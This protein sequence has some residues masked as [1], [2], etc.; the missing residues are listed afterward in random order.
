MIFSSVD[1]PHPDGPS[2]HR[3]SPGATSKLT[4]RRTCVVSKDLEMWLTW[5]RG[6]RITYAAPGAGRRWQNVEWH[7]T[8]LSLFGRVL[9]KLTYVAHPDAFD[10]HDANGADEHQDGAHRQCL[11]V[12]KRTG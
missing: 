4:S 9:S 7:T 5:S 2:R 1:L 12:V 3:I 6:G 11:T 10:D 8:R